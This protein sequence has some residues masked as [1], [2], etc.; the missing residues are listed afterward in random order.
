MRPFSRSATFVTATLGAS[1][2]HPA[3]ASATQDRIPSI[4]PVDEADDASHETIVVTGTARKNTTELSSTAPIQVLTAERLTRQGATELNQSLQELVPSFNFPQSQTNARTSVKGASLRGLAPDDTLVLVNG[5]RRAV[6]ALA[7]TSSGIFHGSQAVDLSVIPSSALERVEVLTDG[8]SAQ[9]GSDAVAGVVNLLLRKNHSGGSVYTNYGLFTD[10]NES[11]Y[12]AGGWIGLGLGKEGYLTLSADANYSGETSRGQSDLRQQYFAG[13][14]REATANRDRS[15]EGSPQLRKLALLANFGLP[16]TD[17]L[18]FYGYLNY[19][20]NRVSGTGSLRPL[21]DSNVRAIFPDGATTT[22]VGR[23]EDIATLAGFKYDPG[24]GDT[25]DLSF[26]YGKSLEKESRYNVVNPSLGPTSP[27]SFRVADRINDLANISVEYGT[28]IGERLWGKSFALLAGVDYRHEA[29]ELRAGQPASWVTGS[30]R[31][32]DGPNAGLATPIGPGVRPDEAGKYSRDVFGA[33]INLEG[34]VTRALS[35]GATG[36]IEHYSDFGETVNGKFAARYEFTPWIALRGSVSTG[37][38]APGLG[39]IGFATSTAQ[40]QTDGS[41]RYTRTVPVNSPI[42]RALGFPDLK[43]EK[44]FNI[45]AGVVLRP[46]PN[47]SLT[48]DAYKINLDDKLAP[49]DNISGATVLSLLN[50]AGYGGTSVVRVFT[51]AGDVRIKGIDVAGRT[52]INLGSAGKLGLTA[53]YTVNDIRVTKVN[54]APGALATLNVNSQFVVDLIE[55]GQPEDKLILGANY[56]KGP[57]SFNLSGTRYGRV[58]SV[59]LSNVASQNY[60]I[61]AQWVANT[62]ISFDTGSGLVLTVGARNLFNSYPD[63]S[64]QANTANSTSRY[65]IQSPDGFDG[66]LLYAD[67]RFSF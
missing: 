26:V 67:L 17:T 15:R 34:N 33:Y 48:I 18:S 5:K 38:R 2:L 52:S 40:P 16:V 20:A 63:W 56:E 22:Q 13:D 61:S 24:N 45:A 28:D 21:D 30:Y 27:T 10:G 53:A 23:N 58:Y 37:Y 59:S 44:S 64:P 57:I 36:R 46:L 8:A 7:K 51:N 43:P 32:I 42:A 41:I 60:Y 11:R 14:T 29:Y 35:I 9:Y 25:I 49:T 50:A 4:A 6:N 12:Q 39:Q 54:R 66:R 3:I 55:R 31:I 62:S 1:I 65:S 19:S 47:T